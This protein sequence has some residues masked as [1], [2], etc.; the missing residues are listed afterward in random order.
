MFI[1]RSSDEFKNI[2]YSCQF[3]P[4][5]F[6]ANIIANVVFPVPGGPVN[7]KCGI[8]FGVF[9]NGLNLSII[10][11]WLIICVI[12]SKSLSCFV[13]WAPKSFLC[14]PV[15]IEPFTKRSNCLM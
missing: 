11:F 8:A 3:F 14:F 7:N 12:F 5:M 6:L 2:L 1:P 10:D 4:S 9:K 15:L 13:L